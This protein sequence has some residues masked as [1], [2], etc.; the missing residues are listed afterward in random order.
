MFCYKRRLK[1]MR[2][3]KQLSKTKRFNK[4]KSKINLKVSKIKMKRFKNC[5]IITESD[6]LNTI[7]FDLINE[8]NI[9]F[10]NFSIFN[11]KDSYNL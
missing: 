5:K 1:K 7:K 8:I 11:N 4:R 3:I 9:V 10:I 2:K 6:D